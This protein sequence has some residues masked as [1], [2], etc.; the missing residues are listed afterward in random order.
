MSIEVEIVIIAAILIIVFSLGVFFQKISYRRLIISDNEIKAKL[1]FRVNELFE[2]INQLQQQVSQARAQLIGEKLLLEKIEVM[3]EER[4]LLMKELMELSKELT[5]K[6]SE[7]AQ[8]I[9]EIQR[10]KK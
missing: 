9:E 4:T 6:K 8:L 2:Q 5:K 1:Q 10:L 7:C 3:K